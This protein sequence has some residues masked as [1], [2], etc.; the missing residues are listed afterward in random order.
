MHLRI[1]LWMAILAFLVWVPTA[2]A[3]SYKYTTIDYPGALNSF[4]CGLN[5]SGTEMVG[6]YPPLHGFRT[7]GK[8]FTLIDVP[9]YSRTSALGVNNASKIAGR[10]G[11]EFIFHGFIK[12][13]NDITVFDVPVAGTA[14]TEAYAINDSD[15]IVGTYYKPTYHG[16]V[17]TGDTFYY[18]DYP[19]TTDTEARGI[20]NKR[21][22]VGQYWD[23]G[24][25]I[26][27]Y[28]HDI[29]SNSYTTIDYPG[30]K[31]TGIFGI[32]D[33]GQMVGYYQD[34]QDK[35]HALVYSGRVFTILKVPGAVNAFAQSID[36]RGNI[37][38]SYQD[39]SNNWHG[40]RATPIIITSIY[41]LLIN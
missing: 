24:Y 18:V 9:G 33:L 1:A 3:I 35:Q 39:G 32:N 27:G 17:K 19:S 34:D 36:L 6:Y 38:G 20:N 5:S 15:Q 37:V 10:C 4:L 29:D 41:S 7:D 11:S 25:K 2:Q 8:T 30:A 13:G 28:V 23:G 14:S 40:F 21:Q 12:T 26:H 22:V 31:A 16:Y